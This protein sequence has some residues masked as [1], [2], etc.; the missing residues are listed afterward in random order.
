MLKSPRRHCALANCIMP[1][2]INS[3]RATEP[4]VHPGPPL[5]DPNARNCHGYRKFVKR[6]MLEN[7]NN[8]YLV[9][10]TIIIRY[11]IELVVSSGGALSRATGTAAVPKPPTIQVH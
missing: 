7:P 4:F 2:F 9:D 1:S 3:C 8:G 6:N 5:Q 10:D 11:T